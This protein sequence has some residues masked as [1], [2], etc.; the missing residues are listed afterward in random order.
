MNNIPFR[1]G[2]LSYVFQ[3]IK[4]EIIKSIANLD[5]IIDSQGA[6]LQKEFLEN[7][8]LPSFELNK[9]QIDREHSEINRDG[10]GSNAMRT[11]F[12][13]PISGDTN[14]LEYNPS[15]YRL[16]KDCMSI[17][18]GGISYVYTSSTDYPETVQSM[19]E[20]DLEDLQFNIENL[21]YDIKG[22]NVHLSS[23]INSQFL[24]RAAQVGKNRQF[25]ES[26]RYPLK[27]DS[28]AKR[29][30]E[31]PVRKKQLNISQ[32]TGSKSQNQEYFLSESDYDSILDAIHHMTLV[33]ERSPKAFQDMEEETLRFLLLV[34]LNGL[35]PGGATGE[36]FNYNGKT[37]I[38]IR[39]KEKNIFIAECK[40]WEGPEYLAKALDQLLGYASWRDT[41]TALI[42]FN[43]NK[44]LSAVLE[45]IPPT[46]KEH[47][48]YKRDMEFK[49]ETG[50][51]YLLNHKDDPNREL[52][53]TVLVFDVP[54]D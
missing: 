11:T 45:K 47:P 44:N 14:L 23:F 24:N 30:Y 26:F 9:D 48:N 52:I 10:F 3:K 34:P 42:I 7:Y 35:F 46:I 21:N 50:F 18:N 53:L 43:R 12:F 4:E 40:F 6:S 36:T 41:K 2:N 20:K 31:I 29:F 32:S 5:H 27:S 17:V 19:F 13:V 37:D 38:L 33:F 22:F 49:S 15:T 8:M 39:Y 1:K 54:G 25:V 51:R 28:V 16:P